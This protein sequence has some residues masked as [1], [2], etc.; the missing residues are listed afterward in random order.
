MYILQGTTHIVVS[1][2]LAYDV[3]DKN[4]TKAF[5]VSKTSGC[6]ASG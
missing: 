3:C 5:H 1:M 2:T 4:L 6:R